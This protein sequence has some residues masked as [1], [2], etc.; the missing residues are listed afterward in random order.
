[1]AKAKAKRKANTKIAVGGKKIK[2]KRAAAKRYKVLGSG[3]V[4]V[5]KCNR[6]HN[7]GPKSRKLKN[8]LRRGQIMR[9]ESMLHVYRCLPNSF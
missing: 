7:T 5:A 9:E 8:S 6:R 1:M 4:K 3:K 2:T